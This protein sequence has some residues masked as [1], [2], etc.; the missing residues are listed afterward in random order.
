VWEYENLNQGLEAISMGLFT[1]LLGWSKIEV[2]V[3]IAKVRAE[4]KNTRIHAYY[5]V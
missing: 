1:R 4:L 3:F 5:E 2:E